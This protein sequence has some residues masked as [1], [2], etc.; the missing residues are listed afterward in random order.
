MDDLKEII[1]KNLVR[2]RT[3]ANLTQLQLATMLNYS[4]KAVSKWER[5]ESIPDVGVLM[6]IAQIYHIKLDDIVNPPPEKVVKPKLNR[7]KKRLL[8]TLLSV[9]LVW[10]IATGIFAILFVIPQTAHYAYLSFIV[11][12][13]ASAVVL[14]VFS[15]IWGTRLTTALACSAV[16]WT[17]VVAINIFVNAFALT[18]KIWIF[19]VV[20]APFQILIV[21]WFVFRKVK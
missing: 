14:L 16:L 11:A 19:Y 2:L 3:E 12:L 20:A 10:F 4:D 8:I 17:L 9:G 5:G 13:F 15:A 6:Q 18:E 1:A 21:L 7:G